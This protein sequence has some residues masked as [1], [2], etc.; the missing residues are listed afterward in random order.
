[1]FSVD[2]ELLVMPRSKIGESDMKTEVT[3]NKEVV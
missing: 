2:Q 3:G 1:M